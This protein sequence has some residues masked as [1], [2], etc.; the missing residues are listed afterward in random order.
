MNNLQLAIAMVRLWF[1]ITL[2]LVNIAWKF[3]RLINAFD[4]MQTQIIEDSKTLDDI[5]VRVTKLEVLV[6]NGANR[7]IQT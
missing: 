4:Q 2:A 1:P 7:G 6:I 5:V 3:G